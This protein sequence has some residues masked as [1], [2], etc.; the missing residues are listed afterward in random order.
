[1]GDENVA[2]L[3]EFPEIIPNVMSFGGGVFD[4]IAADWYTVGMSLFKLE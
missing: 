4:E 1:V 2:L 3:D